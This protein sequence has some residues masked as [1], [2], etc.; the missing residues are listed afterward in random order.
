L[1]QG[2]VDGVIVAANDPEHPWR[3]KPT[4]ATRAEELTKG[5]STKHCLVPTNALL[6]EA[7]FERGLKKIGI[8]GCPCHIEA[9][10]KIQRASRPRK[11]AESIA[12]T[13]SVYC[14]TNFWW[15]ATRHI[16]DEECGVGDFREVRE[17]TY[18][19]GGRPQHFI[20]RL[21][22]GTERKSP[23]FSSFLNYL[24]PFQAERCSV[25]Y[26]WSGELAD[27][28]FGDL[29]IAF[30]LR[31]PHELGWNSMLVRTSTGERLLSEA[32]KA[33]Y[34]FA[35]RSRAEYTIAAFGCE[36]KKHGSAHNLTWRKKHGW[37]IPNFG[38]DPGIPDPWPVDCRNAH[39]K[40]DPS[41]FEGV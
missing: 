22:D 19:G 26:D 40:V 31:P 27:I 8:V 15:E 7:V 29:Y 20:S 12:L 39:L 2:I 24:F 11:I 3:M 13:L 14:A 37:V 25:C 16:F 6:K 17:F 36:C 4:I 21:A 41:Y 35:R 34:L 9:I 30:F 5:M 23:L 38:Y 28:S 32:M 18:R 10:R 33:G 1:E